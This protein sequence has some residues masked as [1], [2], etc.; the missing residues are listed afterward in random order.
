MIS[1]IYK[2]AL[3]GGS[4][5]RRR[6]PPSVA[7]APSAHEA[8]VR[9]SSAS[10][11]DDFFCPGIFHYHKCARPNALTHPHPPPKDIYAAAAAVCININLLPLISFTFALGVCVN[12]INVYVMC[13]PIRIFMFSPPNEMKRCGLRPKLVNRPFS[14]SI[15]SCL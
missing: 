6:R 8:L 1:P 15:G 11:V 5:L 13:Y 2:N 9:E 7:A 14:M 4:S 3:R 10:R 12:M